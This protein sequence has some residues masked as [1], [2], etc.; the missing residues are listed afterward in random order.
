MCPV[1]V[2][3]RAPSAPTE[4][5][6]RS[7]TLIVRSA[8]PVTNHSFPGSKAIART[9][10][11]C[12]ETTAPSFQGACHSGLGADGADRRDTT[13]WFA[14]PLP[15][16]PPTAPELGLK[17]T[18]LPVDAD[19]DPAAAVS[20]RLRLSISCCRCRALSS[21]SASMRWMMRVTS[22]SRCFSTGGAPAAAF[23]TAV[24]ESVPLRP[25]RAAAAAAAAVVGCWVPSL[26][27]A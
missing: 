14:S 3:F 10:P 22:V 1:S 5:F 27:A 17:S 19:E 26:T 11:R 13:S 2:S 12:A 20:P 15:S 16:S 9:H 21:F 4:A 7:H 6:A 23:G 18:R 24:L 25:I 8:D